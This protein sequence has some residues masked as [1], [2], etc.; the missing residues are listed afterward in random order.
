[1]QILP[2]DYSILPQDTGAA[3]AA[4]ASGNFA[5]IFQNSLNSDETDPVANF[6]ESVHSAINAVNRGEAENV[7]AAL[8]DDEN[9]GPLV[10]APYSRHTLNGVLYTLDEVTFTKKELQELRASLVKAGAPE[11]ALSGLDALIQAPDGAMLAQVMASLHLNST[12]KL[13][14]SDMDTLTGLLNQIDPSGE[15]AASSMD[16]MQQGKGLQALALIQ[17]TFNDAAHN[18]TIDISREDMATLAKGLGLPESVQQQLQSMFGNAGGLR[19]DSDQFGN[20]MNPARAYLGE[21]ESKQAK[22]DEAAAQT[23]RQVVRKARE[24]MDKEAQAESLQ[25][26]EVQQSKAMIDRT[27]QKQTRENLEAAL[28]AS[29]KEAAAREQAARFSEAGGRSADAR[30]SAVINKTDN[31]LSA[32]G[33]GKAGADEHTARANARRGDAADT[34]GLSMRYGERSEAAANED[35]LRRLQLARQGLADESGDAAR[36]DGKTDAERIGLVQDARHAVAASGDGQKQSAQNDPGGNPHSGQDRT[37]DLSAQFLTARQE[38][39]RFEAARPDAAR[40]DQQAPLS[41]QVGQQV[42]DGFLQAMRGNVRRLDVELHP[43]ELGAITLTLTM[44]NGE[45]SANIRSEKSETAELVSQQ[46]ETIRINLEQQ[47]FKVDKLEV[48]LQN[49]RKDLAEGSADQWQNMQQHN[50]RQE[51]DARREELAHLQNLSTLRNSRLYPEENDLA[52]PMH[53]L[54]ET[55]RYATRSLHVVA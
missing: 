51:E 37:N 44:R 38:T 48:G 18:G 24:R 25:S 20:L 52:Q 13:S 40:Q 33:M 3:V 55:A 9:T 26:R 19:C 28:D 50:A 31:G 43:A 8:D 29:Q 14:D 47:G 16:L 23:I 2:S 7:K 15:L 46:L 35:G 10:D 27:V 22:L 53:I 30:Q 54:G 6:L 17:R 42:E 5:G 39:P 4:S 12:V 41:R 49:Q 36:T 1:M 45:V 21:R 11:D 32:T 34:T